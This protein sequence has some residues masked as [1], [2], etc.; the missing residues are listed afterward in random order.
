MR[1]ELRNEKLNNDNLRTIL[2]AP[3][4]ILTP[5]AVACQRCAC[6]VAA[7]GIIIDLCEIAAAITRHLSDGNSMSTESTARRI[8]PAVMATV[9]AICDR[10]EQAWQGGLPEL[11][12]F[13]AEGPAECRRLLLCELASIELQYRHSD[14]AK[15]GSIEQL[16]AAHPALADELRGCAV[17]IK[18]SCSPAFDTRAPGGSA[19]PDSDV[20]LAAMVQPT[21]LHIRCPHCASPVELVADTPDE[22]VTCRACGSTFCLV[23]RDGDDATAK[24]LHT[25]GRF[26]LISR[27]GVGGFGSVWKALD[28]EL[29]RPVALK[30]PRRSQ[31]AG[32]DVEFFFREARAAAQL[33]H[34]HI[35]PVYEIGRADDTVFIVSEFVRGVTL[36]DWMKAEKPSLREAATL[37]AVVAEAL[38]HAHSRG[39]V[40]RDLKP[41]NIMIDEEGR[42]RIMD[43]GLAKRE[44]GEVTMTC[45]GQILG[46]AAYMSPEQA[47]GKAHWIDRRADVYSLGVTLY[48]LAT[49]ELPYRGNMEVQLTS[50][51][52]DDAPDPRKLN[53]LIHPDLAT[54]CLK[55]LE[56]DPNRRYGSAGAAAA[57]L[58]RFLAGE[59]ILARPI[60]RLARF[61]RWTRRKPALAAAAAMATFLAVA[62]PIAA[63]VISWQ[64]QRLDDQVHELD[65]LVSG[66]QQELRDRDAVVASLRNELE[67]L[68]TPTRRRLHN[69]ATT[70]RRQILDAVLSQYGDNLDEALQS[71]DL[72]PADRLRLHLAWAVMLRENEQSERALRHFSAA[73]DL[74]QQLVAGRTEDW[75]LQAALADCLENLAELHGAAGDN[76]AAAAAKAQAMQIRRQL[77]ESAPGVAAR[78][79][80][81]EAYFDSVGSGPSAGRPTATEALQRQAEL[82]DEIVA[83]WPTEAAA[84]YEAACRLTG[85][86]PILNWAERR[87]D[88]GD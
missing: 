76:A 35:I 58:R 53:R 80:L 13:L 77:A 3:S 34:P 66:Q 86:L 52:F 48:Q 7:P 71:P 62:G 38:D 9:D 81:I 55:C 37:C 32:E 60:S 85:R 1:R 47:A 68:E 40:H 49:G 79:D 75:P 46:T 26:E 44:T 39:V 69:A 8:S 12:Q 43:F 67:R 22:D 41:S 73:R 51:L 64:N 10:F 82:H 18:E 16:I 5:V 19:A 72:D 87:M 83:N 15:G 65:E 50:K 78:V 54:I 2:R 24:S 56:R 28:P 17:E 45:D 74:L 11:E 29:E 42:P 14:A 88:V 57:E 25:V 31:L 4:V 70:W 23:E 27:L 30:I 36:A 20:V 21:G 84:A 61:A 63:V 33:R 6:R 59:P